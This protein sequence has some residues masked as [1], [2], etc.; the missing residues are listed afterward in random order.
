[1]ELKQVI[2][3]PKDVKMSPEKLGVQIAHASVTAI[4]E[5]LERRSALMDWYENG[6]GQKKVVLE[7]ETTDQL[8]DLHKKAREAGVSCYLIKDAGRTELKS[9]TITALGFFPMKDKEINQWT[10]NL[11]LH[12][13]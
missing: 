9:K 6:S 13:Q 10:G 7:I 4:L 5:N 3:I 12:K 1:M 8:Q 11:K 2:V